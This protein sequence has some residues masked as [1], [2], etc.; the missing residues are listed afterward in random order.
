MGAQ[1][2]S[3]S[4][5][6]AKASKKREICSSETAPM[7]SKATAARETA[8]LATAWAEAGTCSRSPVSWTTSNR[9][10]ARK[11]R[12]SSSGTTATRSPP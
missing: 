4:S 9:S 10:P 5:R 11:A 7:R 8:A 2:S 3:L 6:A 12:A 1:A